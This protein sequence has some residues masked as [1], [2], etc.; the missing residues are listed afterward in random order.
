MPTRSA[1]RE[2]PWETFCLLWYAGAKDTSQVRGLSKNPRPVPCEEGKLAVQLDR[3]QKLRA[4]VS[5]LCESCSS[6]RVR[7]GQKVLS[8]QSMPSTDK[9]ST[10]GLC[11]NAHGFS[12]H[13]AAGRTGAA[14]PAAPPPQNRNFHQTLVRLTTRR[15]SVRLIVGEKGLLKFLFAPLNSTTNA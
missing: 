11:A 5:S 6:V 14:S 13:A 7:A 15:L 9:P 12:L 1:R 4:L 10:R 3:A 8:L 2:R